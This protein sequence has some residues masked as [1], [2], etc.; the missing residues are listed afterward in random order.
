MK[1]YAPENASFLLPFQF[2]T[3]ALIAD[4]EKCQK[5]NF[6]KNYVPANY[7]GNGYI[8]PLRSVEGRLDFPAASPNDADRFKDTIA[9]KECD[10]FNEVVDTFLCKKEA[11]RLMNLPPGKVVNTHTDHECGY[12][13]GIFR[14]HIPIITNDQVAFTLNGKVLKMKPGE[15]W[16]T[17]VNLPH[18][19]A[20]KGE[21]N[22]IHLV[23]DCIRNKWSDEIFGSI[24]FDFAQERNVHEVLPKATVLRMIEEL[25]I[26]D[27]PDDKL[28]I[29]KLKNEHD[30]S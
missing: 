27:S 4:L 10:Y 9:L 26:R 29:E 18:G 13:D 20:N 8:L 25:E 22:R 1:Y 15:V 2:D 24:G 16:Y 28:F 7:N 11:V 23:I 30:I 5:F 3:Q 14:L 17:N 21:T 19:V 12:E 6:L